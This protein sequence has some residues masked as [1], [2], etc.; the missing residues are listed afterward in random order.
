VPAFKKHRHRNR[1]FDIASLPGLNGEW[2]RVDRIR[3]LMGDGVALRT[4]RA[5]DAGLG[6]VTAKLDE[7]LEAEKEKND[8]LD[9]VPAGEFGRPRV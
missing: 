1:Y 6:R 5:F 3:I 4:K 7:S 9:G 2:Q 8:F